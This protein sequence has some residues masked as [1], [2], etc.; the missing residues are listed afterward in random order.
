MH[1]DYS[2]TALLEVDIQNDFCPGYTGKEGREHLPGAMMI[3]GGDAVI[4]PLNKAASLVF[5]G[6][7]K[8]LASQDW[9]P[10]SHISFASSHR[11]KKPGDI[12]LCDVSEEAV[13]EFLDK[14]PNLTDPIPAAVQ[15]VL[16]PD[17]CIQETEGAAFHEELE[18]KYIDFV[19][20]K[21]YHKNIDSYSVFFE[22]DRCT[23]TD[24]HGYLKQLP[25]ETLIIGGLATDYCVFYSVMDS[26]RLR[27]KT[28][29][30]TDAVAGVGTPEGSI[31]RAL[32]TMKDSGA[33]FAASG[34][35]E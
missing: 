20:R 33:F 8:V 30:L 9:H 23:S 1:I 24:L 32:K 16:W 35:F 11:K 28:I 19:F 13:Q 26:L 6:G 21:G 25:I 31:E 34:D 12:V 2:K 22:N 3:D 17:H 10:V 18:T 29:L 27:Y 15:Q 5:Q 14:Y 7:G 4:P